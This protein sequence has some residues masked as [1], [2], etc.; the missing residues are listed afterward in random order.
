MS[1]INPYRPAAEITEP[2]DRNWRD[3]PGWVYRRLAGASSG[4]GTLLMGVSMLLTFAGRSGLG[5]ALLISGLGLIGSGYYWYGR[6]ERLA[7][8]WAVISV[9][10]L[11]L[12]MLLV[13]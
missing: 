5:A 2:D 1:D 4:F 8:S 11:G 13:G 9:S 3:E 10:V 6:E 7:V 12:A